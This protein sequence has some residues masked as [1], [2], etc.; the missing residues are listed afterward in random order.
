VDWDTVYI[1]LPL[2]SDISYRDDNQCSHALEHLVDYHSM[3]CQCGRG[4]MSRYNDSVALS[5]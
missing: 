1:S 3:L 2:V 4:G 5:S